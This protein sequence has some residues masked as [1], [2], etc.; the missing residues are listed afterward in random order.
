VT[1]EERCK[2]KGL[3]E[4]SWYLFNDFKISATSKYDAVTIDSHW[5][6]I[7]Y[8]FK[9]KKKTFGSIIINFK[10]C[11]KIFFFYFK[12]SK[13]IL[14]EKNIIVYCDALNGHIVILK[15]M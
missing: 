4:G 6:V 1:N 15:L 14:K 7:K 13:S 9:K 3:K 10:F 2:K 8:F 11:P 5:K 12:K